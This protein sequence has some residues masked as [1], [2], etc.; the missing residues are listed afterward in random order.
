MYYARYLYISRSNELLL[1]GENM[2]LTVRKKILTGF[3]IVSLLLTMISAI[4]I[5][6]FQSVTDSYS[7]IV[8]RRVE[9]QTNMKEIVIQTQQQSLAVQNTLMQ[10]DAA[11]QT[12]QETKIAIDELIE[13]T[14][15]MLT[16]PEFLE[17][18]NTLQQNNDDLA[19]NYDAFLDYLNANPTEVAKNDY[20][21]KELAPITTNMIA[22]ASDYAAQSIDIMRDVNA[23]NKESVSTIITTIIVISI[24]TIIAAIAIG[25]FISEQ[26]GRPLLKITEASK[27]MA[28]KD[29]TMEPINVKNQDEL[30]ELALSFNTMVESLR[31]LIQNV[32]ASTEQVAASSEQ[33]MASAEQT[34]Q[35]TNQIAASIQE[36][37]SGSKNQEHSAEQNA[38]VVQEMT[39]GVQRVADATSTVVTAAEETTKEA[40]EGNET[41]QHVVTQMNRIHESTS[42][43]AAAIQSLENRSVE[44]V[45]ILEVITNLSDQTNL[46]ALNAA[47]EA[48][49][50][51]E[52]G[53][54]FAVV[55]DEVRKL[56]EQSKQSADQVAIL[57]REIQADTNQA[58]QAMQQGTDSV[59]TGMTVVQQAGAGFQKIQQSIHNMTSR[60]QEISAFAQDISTNVVQVNMTMEQ[61]TSEA[62]QTSSN[63]EHMAAA[64]EQQLA[65]MEEIAASSAALSKRAEE[66]LAQVG[67]FKV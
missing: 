8:D 4:S 25:I 51:G 3:M 57:V 56:A 34:T 66:L 54:G 35:A 50:A 62:K 2:K 42:D 46:L 1:R 58:V 14:R 5:Y 23:E 10:G 60:I 7:D 19:T 39:T 61:V 40:E 12:F 49:R 9:I 29:L 67:E 38:R 48:A 45:N 31:E 36:V 41:I 33:L 6:F 59:A 53:K 26:I 37:A 64:S 27:T 20:W 55:A 17:A 11:S 63:T 24:V 22:I 32:Y 16:L 65:T 18:L 13:N 15:V 44:I 30:G 47:I 21:E 52:H 43:S 28:N